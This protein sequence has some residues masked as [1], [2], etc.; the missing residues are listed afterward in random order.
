MVGGG[1]G[2][3]ACSGPPR[4]LRASLAGRPKGSLCARWVLG[5]DPGRPGRGPPPIPGSGAANVVCG[6]VMA[7]PSLLLSSSPFFSPPPPLL[8][9]PLASKGGAPRTP[10]ARPPFWGLGVVKQGAPWP[11]PPTGPGPGGWWGLRVFAGGRGAGFPGGGAG[12][13]SG[14][15]VGVRGFGVTILYV[16]EVGRRLLGEGRRPRVFPGTARC[17]LGPREPLKW[18][19]REFFRRVWIRRNSWRSLEPA[20]S[21]G[22]AYLPGDDGCSRQR[23]RPELRL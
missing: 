16:C 1:S 23:R 8:S 20:R 13:G 14:G 9:P 21:I 17:V 2:L 7:L 6:P 11:G 10:D 15:G 12:V 18:S 4:L 3:R 5:G 19:R 22:Q